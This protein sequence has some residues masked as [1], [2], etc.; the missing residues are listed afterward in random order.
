[1]FRRVASSQ[2]R[3]VAGVG[4]G[5]AAIAA[6]GA[7]VPE[8]ALDRAVTVMRSSRRGGG[9]RARGLRDSNLMRSLVVLLFAVAACVVAPPASFADHTGS[10]I[11]IDEYVTVRDNT[12]LRMQVEY[13]ENPP[14]TGVPTLLIYQG[15]THKLDYGVPGGYVF[16]NVFYH[17]GFRSWASAQGYALMVV[18]VRGAGCSGGSYDFLSEKEA[19]DGE[20]VIKWITTQSWSNGKVAMI[21]DS[22]AGFEQLPVAAR[23]PAGL[24]AIAPG[25]PIADLYRD[26][27][28]PGGISNKLLPSQFSQAILIDGY[29]QAPHESLAVTP[30]PGVLVDDEAAQLEPNKEQCLENQTAALGGLT[31]T[32][33]AFLATHRWDDDAMR[34]RAPGA[35]I[36]DI[37]APTLTHVA[38][39]D[40]VLGSRAIVNLPRVGGPFHAVLSN[41][42]HGLAGFHERLKEFLD[43]YVRGIDNGFG[44]RDPIEVWWESQRGPDP[45]ITD[46]DPDGSEGTR[47][48]DVVPRWTSGLSKMPAAQGQQTTLFLSKGGELSFEPGTGGPDSYVYVGG[49]GQYRG[50]AVPAGQPAWSAPPDSDKSLV[51]TSPPLEKDLVVLGS[52][53]L[54]L[55]LDST[56]TDTDLQAVLTEIRPDGK[57]T[58]VQAG[59]LR[60]SH[61]KL[62]GERSTATR[63]FHT[64]QAADEQ[65]LTPLKPELMRVEIRPFGHVFRAGSKLRL[66]IEAPPLTTG[67]WSFESLPGPANNRVYHDSAYPSALKLETLPGHVAPVTY[68]ECGSVIGQ[69]CRDTTP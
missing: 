10:P 22:H 37:K 48:G 43:F 58:Y 5:V 30:F 29:P 57:E 45:D 63:P 25:V 40:P 49:S 9:H 28:Y 34:E 36:A 42:G 50:G 69:P 24:V 13:P 46:A 33:A 20:D 59:W 27:G 6:A 64:H 21:G 32:S 14:A 53:T 3:R 62:D 17:G 68:P 67:N 11:D 1:M 61:R 8:L 7:G 38:W 51:Y 65:M 41:G 26:V 4:L 66:S 12:K 56:A 18:S 16:E 52:G 15:Y 19:E 39:Q 23:Q 44:A 54:D 31:G 60:A 55:W 2:T 35:Q 47:I